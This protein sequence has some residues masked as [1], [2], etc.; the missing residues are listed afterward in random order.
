MNV[1]LKKLIVIGSK[2]LIA[3]CVVFAFVTGYYFGGLVA[4]WRSLVGTDGTPSQVETATTSDEIWTCSMHPEIRM[5]KPGKCPKCGMDL[6]KAKPAKAVAVKKPRYACSMFCVPPM[7]K[8]GKCPVCGMNMVKVEDEGGID[9]EAS[10]GPTLTLSKR[11]Q[12]LAQVVLAPVERRFV[13]AEVRMVGKVEFDETRMAHITAWAPGRLDRLYVDYTGLTVQKGDH[14]VYMFSPDLATAQTEL[15]NVLWI[16]KTKNLEVDFVNESVQRDIDAA[17]DRLRLLGLTEGQIE[18]IE[19]RGTASDHVTIYA[20]TGGVVVHKNAVEGMY[21]NTGTR[22]YTIADL[23]RVW[24]KL[25]AYESD[26][27]WLRYGQQVTFEIEAYPGETFR[28]N[29]SFIDPVL[30][31]E[32]RTVK[33]RVNVDN[34]DGRLKPNMFVRAK[35]QSRVASGGRVMEPALAGKW[36]CPMHPEILKDGPGDCDLCEMPLVPTDSLYRPIDDDKAEAPLVVPVSAP[37]ITGKRAVV[38]VARP[39][40][41][42]TYEGREVV[43]GPR[44]GDYY[45]VREGLQEGELVV[46]NGNFKIDSAM[47]IRTKPSMMSPTGGG[48]GGGHKHD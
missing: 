37:L 7:D 1:D 8:P 41:Q 26:L 39:D 45:I 22:I 44:A 27:K 48:Q 12:R 40:A 25:D 30:N 15:L 17:R 23:S 9:E 29:I 20:P 36:M 31:A 21:V 16:S 2:L 4:D 24:V 3:M 18:E 11:A 35:V 43:L 6:V 38:Y 10:G 14:L 42:R 34:T 28:G 47:Q 13:S 32:T 19:R 33:I 5:P 46:V